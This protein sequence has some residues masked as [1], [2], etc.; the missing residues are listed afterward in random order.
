SDDNL[1]SYD[2]DDYDPDYEFHYSTAQADALALAY[3]WTTTGQRNAGLALLESEATAEYHAL[4]AEF[5]GAAYDQ[6][7]A[8]A[9]S[10]DQVDAISEGY[11]WTEDQLSYSISSGLLAAP[12]ANTG[13][14][15]EDPNIIGRDIVISA[16]NIG[17]TLDENIEI[18]LSGGVRSLSAEER[19][20]LATA[21][22]DDVAVDSG[23]PDLITI[24][25]R[26]DVDILSTG[27]ITATATG[28]AF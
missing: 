26:D 25:Q 20:A 4:H 8:F 16:A 15:D 13:I 11:S 9:L 6:N 5:G 3:G 28:N 21:E 14:L 1:I 24:V 12:G 2:A 18:D 23:N 17:R 10:Q 19:R 7:Y 27:N 22:F